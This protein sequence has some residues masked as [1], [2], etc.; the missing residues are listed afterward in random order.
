V[1]VLLHHQLRA[2]A[3]WRILFTSLP[4]ICHARAADA[5]E[6]HVN[7]N[8]WPDKHS[9][10]GTHISDYSRS[11]REGIFSI[12]GSFLIIP[13]TDWIYTSMAAIASLPRK[14]P[15]PWHSQETRAGNTAGNPASIPSNPVLC[16]QPPLHPSTVETSSPRLPA[17]RRAGRSSGAVL[18]R[19]RG[20]MSAKRSGRRGHQPRN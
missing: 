15:M 3:P 12:M 19:R 7:G 1:V 20:R 16:L 13:T 2:D 6:R 4:Q 5:P 10:H 9:I 8:I 14:P 11:H 18:R 17:H